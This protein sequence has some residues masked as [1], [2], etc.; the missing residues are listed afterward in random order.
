M[1]CYVRRTVLRTKGE[2]A[3]FAEGHYSAPGADGIVDAAVKLGSKLGRFAPLG[4]RACYRTRSVCYRRNMRNFLPQT[5][6]PT[7]GIGGFHDHPCSQAHCKGPSI[8]K[9][10]GTDWT[11]SEFR[12][13]SSNFEAFTGA[14]A[15][16]HSTCGGHQF[17]NVAYRGVSECITACQSLS[18][19]AIQQTFAPNLQR[20]NAYALWLDSPWTGSSGTSGHPFSSMSVL[21]QHKHENGKGQKTSKKH[22][23]GRDDNDEDWAPLVAEST[24]PSPDELTG[25]NKSPASQWYARTVPGNEPWRGRSHRNTPSHL[26]V[27]APFL[28]VAAS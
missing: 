7:G 2:Q 9:G 28:T 21:A 4:G 19:Q 23:C 26:P 5:R 3:A 15:L 13:K 27:L 14:S 24:P 12:P 16:F 8:E 6:A 22:G 20:V 17:F 18:Q 11:N 10:Q 1:L 25:P